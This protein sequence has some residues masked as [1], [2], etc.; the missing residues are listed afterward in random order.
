MSL[1]IPRE[2]VESLR[3]LYRGCD[4]RRSVIPR[5][6]VESKIADFKESWLSVTCDPVIPREGVESDG[7]TVYVVP[8][9][10]VV[11]PREGVESEGVVTSTHATITV[12]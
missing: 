9:A 8:P 4:A 2:G 7:T 12:K 1:V 10:I 5:E 11:I 3:R 6:G